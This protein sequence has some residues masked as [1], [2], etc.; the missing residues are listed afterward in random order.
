MIIA[1]RMKKN[2]ATATP[3]MSISDAS[4]KMKAEKVH[5]LPVLDDDRRL[6]G[7]ISEKDILLAAPSPASTLSTY[8]INY[9]LSKLKVKNIMS[10]NPVTITRETTIEEAVRLMVEN[11]LSCLPVMEKG[12]LCGIVSKS[13]LFK[14]LLEMLGAKHEGIRVEALVEDKVGVVAGLSEKFTSSGINIISFGTIDG[15]DP[16]H[17]VLTFKLEH[18]TEKQVRAILEPVSV[19][20]D[21]R[22]V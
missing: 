20:L 4:A 18:A 17:K 22:S 3:D 8:E 9:L 1:D 12:Y 11:D 2:P 14:I 5:R 6:V 19:S 16:E 10:R 21:I 7:V 15:P 13:D